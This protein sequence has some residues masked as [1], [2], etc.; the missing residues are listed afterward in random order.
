MEYVKCQQKYCPINKK[1]LKQEA[2]K[3]QLNTTKCNNL[4]KNYKKS[5]IKRVIK[6]KNLAY[7]SMAKIN[8]KRYSMYSKTL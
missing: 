8:K 5:T 1:E 3:L 6:C 4:M 7:V 2:N